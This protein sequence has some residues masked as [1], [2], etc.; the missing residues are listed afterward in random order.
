M[1]LKYIGKEII[2]LKKSGQLYKIRP[3]QEIN[4]TKR[5]LE[6]F[7]DRTEFKLVQYKKVK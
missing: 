1:K 3:G 4:V 7:A 6:R 2:K 5:E